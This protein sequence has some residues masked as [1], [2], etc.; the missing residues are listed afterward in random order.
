MKSLATILVILSLCSCMVQ[1]QSERQYHWADAV[2]TSIKHP[3][4]GAS[5]WQITW[6][7]DQVNSNEYQGDTTGLGY[8]IGLRRRTLIQR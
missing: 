4:R 7:C 6:S 1:R 3:Y 8:Y 5:I 2:I